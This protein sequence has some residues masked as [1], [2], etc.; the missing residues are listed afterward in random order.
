MRLGLLWGQELKYFKTSQSTPVGLRVEK[1]Q[2][3]VLVTTGH[4]GIRDFKQ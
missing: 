2:N 3:Y 4:D 1:N